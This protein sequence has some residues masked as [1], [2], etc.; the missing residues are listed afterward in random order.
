[1]AR[2]PA[3]GKFPSPRAPSAPTRSSAI[4]VRV[5]TL[6]PLLLALCAC[7]ALPMTRVRAQTTT[8]EDGTRAAARDLAAEGIAAYQAG[9]FANASRKLEKAYR[10]FS[11][12]TL[13]CG[14]R[15]PA[16]NL[17]TGSR[18]LSAFVRRSVR[19]LLRATPTCSAAFAVGGGAVGSTAPAS[20][21]NQAASL[22]VRFT[23]IS[24]SL[25]GGA[26]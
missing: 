1:M 18:R 11:T 14:P 20:S 23:S 3:G 24:V 10:L 22:A 26:E 13:G 25:E 7:L 4:G 8:P 6:P 9:D 5:R 16:I 19:L 12:P 17:V 21:D 15:A 2:R